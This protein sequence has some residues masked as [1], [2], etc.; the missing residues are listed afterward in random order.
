MHEYDEIQLPISENNEVYALFKEEFPSLHVGE[1]MPTYEYFKRVWTFHCARI[2][3]ITEK[4]FKQCSSCEHLKYVI[5]EAVKAGLD[6]KE[7]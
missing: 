3:V 7:L 4:C 2:K 1:Q 6:T 5:I